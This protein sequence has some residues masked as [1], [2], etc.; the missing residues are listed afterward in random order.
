MGDRVSEMY[1]A[2]ELYYERGATM[3]GVARQMRTSRSTVSRLL[4]EAKEAGIVRIIVVRP[5]QR[6]EYG[7]LLAGMFGIE[8]QVVPVPEL[9]GDVDRLRLVAKVAAQRLGAYAA[10][11][12]DPVVGIAW[13]TTLEQVVRQLEPVPGSRATIVQING[14]ANPSTSGIPYAGMILQDAG[15]ALGDRVVQFP[16]PAFFDEEQT[17]TVLWRERFVRRML[18]LR[19]RMDLAVFS[20]GALSGQVASHVYAGGYLS[21]DEIAALEADGVVGDVGTVMLRQ[22]GSWADIAINRRASGMTPGELAEVP[23]RL[24]VVGSPG[25][26]RAL[27]GALRAGVVTRLVVDDAT[28]RNT[29]AVLRAG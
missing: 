16:V 17:R 2:A 26:A 13:G 9:V 20:V 14:A 10:G 8:V 18:D 5:E 6:T 29:V 15:R 3:D 25:K 12:V 22:D 21:G 7:D 11:A 23:D 24:C 27:A 4:A 28:A 1:R 19:R